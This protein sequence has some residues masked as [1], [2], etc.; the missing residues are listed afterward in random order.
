[1]SWSSCSAFPN[2]VET[3]A[4]MLES[5]IL[6]PIMPE[7]E[8]GAAAGSARSSPPSARRRIAPDGL[9]RLAAI[10]PRDRH[11]A[12]SVAARLKL[13]NKAKK[14]LG[15]AAGADLMSSP[16]A[17]AYRIGT[18]CA[19]DRLLLAG[20][21]ADAAQIRS[22]EPPRLPIGGGELI[23]RG[24]KE[25]PIV[26]RTLR[27]IDRCGPTRAFPTARRS[28]IWSTVRCARPALSG[29]GR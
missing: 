22:W 7:I 8:P 26:A 15:C 23:K 10:L 21:C 9:R 18:D 5:G 20:Q 14:R 16:Q 6:K 11:L 28:K 12:E 3:V 29:G 13:S 19:L 2:P 24:L 17:L 4:L 25:G 1:M 27:T